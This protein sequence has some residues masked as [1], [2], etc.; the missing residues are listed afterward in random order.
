MSNFKTTIPV[1]IQS[2]KNLL[3]PD[4]DVESVRWNEEHKE[5]ELLWHNRRLITPYSFYQDFT[6]DQLKAGE[7]PKSVTAREPVTVQ[8]PLQTKEPLTI[9]NVVDVKPGKRVK[10]AVL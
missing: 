3:P 6:I 5:V 9:T 10:K 4:S 2:V 7:F 8:S 1:D